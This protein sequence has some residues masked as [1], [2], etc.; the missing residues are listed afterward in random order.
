MNLTRRHFFFGSFALP[1]LA[2]RKAVGEQPNIL[3]ILVDDLPSW[4][5]GCYGNTE[6]RTPN[7][8]LLAQTGTRFINHYA[9]SPMAEPARASLLTGRTP[10]QLKD[11]GE[12]T[13]A[14]LLAGIG[15]VCGDTS[16]GAAALQFLDAQS[17]GK[18]FFLTASFAPFA[19]LPS[20][21]GSYAQ[22][23]FETLTQEAPARNA[24]RGKE[25]LGANLVANLRKVAAATTTLDSEIGRLVARLTQ[26]KLLGKPL[27]IFTAP[28]DRS[29]AGTVGL[30]RCLRSRETCTRRWRRR[31]SGLDRTRSALAVRPEVV[32]AY[33]LSP[34][35]LRHHPAELP[36]RNLRPQL[37]S[38]VTGSETLP[39]NSWRTFLSSP[40]TA[41]RPWRRSDRY[42][43]ILRDEGKGRGNCTTISWM[44]GRG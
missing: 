3:L 36:D 20:D 17:A 18:P 21:A 37:H 23:K 40:S 16:G 9:A 42:K 34:R 29:S 13:L 28:T 4:L 38:P 30:G 26:K 2:A 35:H 39:R 19:N 14:K 41:A 7:I 24:A 11:S 15:Y 31:C 22:V 33:D 43:L 6:V 10:M 32:S 25:M 12:V 1:A 27:I 5:L 8:D 44:R